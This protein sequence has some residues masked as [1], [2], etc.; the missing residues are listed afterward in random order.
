[1]A[2]FPSKVAGSSTAPKVW[3]VTG[4]SAG[5]GRVLVKEVLARG[6]YV[7]ASARNIE[8][9]ENLETDSNS[10]GQC[11][12]MCLDVSSSFESIRETIAEAVK[13]WGRIDVLVHNAGNAML[14]ISE[15]VGVEG[16]QKQFAT[17]FYGPLNITHAVLPY[18]RASRSGTVVSVG[19]RSSWKADVLML[20]PYASSKAALS[21]AAEALA[22]ELAPFDI[23]VLEICPGSMRT[24][25]FEKLILLPPAPST[26]SDRN[27]E[28]PQNS[29]DNGQPTIN[30]Y[31]PYRTGQVH[32]LRT[33]NGKQ[34]GD[35]V[36]VA[37]A[38]VDLVR[39]EGE[40]AGWAVV[41]KAEDSEGSTNPDFVSSKALPSMLV[42]GGDAQRDVRQK[43][44][45]VLQGVEEWEEVGQS[46]DIALHKP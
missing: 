41:A 31:A 13:I 36:R 16:Y 33:L 7:I 29:E 23:R 5:L 1:M 11:K 46:I 42:L 28:I 15:E 32:F 20:G 17:N 37:K 38:I 24:R 45:R 9:I 39:V 44:T 25:N 14:G 3:F 43:C 35:P 2:D 26:G 12:V 18:M 30:D 4:T 27:E 21:A 8:D 22:V 10:K 40:F 19:S 6:D 34:P